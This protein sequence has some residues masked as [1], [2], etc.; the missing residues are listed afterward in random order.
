MALNTSHPVRLEKKIIDA[1]KPIARENRRS[2]KGQIECWLLAAIRDAAAARK[3][4]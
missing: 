2:V 1:V 4:N 3:G